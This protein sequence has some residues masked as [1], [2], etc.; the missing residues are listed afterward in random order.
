[1]Y[2]TVTFH[3]AKK[4]FHCWLL[5]VCGLFYVFPLSNAIG[6]QSDPKKCQRSSIGQLIGRECVIKLKLLLFSKSLFFFYSP[7]INFRE[8]IHF[9]CWNVTLVHFTR[10]YYNRLSVSHCSTILL[11]L[12][13]RSFEWNFQIKLLTA[14]FS[15]P[16]EPNEK[17][18]I[19]FIL[20]NINY[21]QLIKVVMK[22]VCAICVTKW[23]GIE[24]WHLLLIF[25][26]LL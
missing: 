25:L 14:C 16:V 10:N 22:I 6:P 20:L 13:C 11:L 24:Q 15:S 1:M 5:R 7:G 8:S 18:C 12:I 3:T 21:G 4:H 23:N 9:V 19:L 17:E 26:L 2:Y